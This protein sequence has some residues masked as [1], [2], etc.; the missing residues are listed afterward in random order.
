MSCP[1]V[2]NFTL[3]DD[4][5]KSEWWIWYSW[6]FSFWFVWLG[7]LWEFCP[8][9]EPHW[10]ISSNHVWEYISFGFNLICHGVN[11]SWCSIYVFMNAI[12]WQW[13]IFYFS[14]YNFHW[15]QQSDIN[16]YIS[17]WDFVILGSTHIMK[18]VNTT[19]GRYRLILICGPITMN[20]PNKC[21]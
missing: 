10:L 3:I 4:L 19:H 14:L 8:A 5:V 15:I 12:L 21:C 9:L 16:S 1:G 11:V 2:I 6:L 13:N 18:V 7:S 20:Y 17:A